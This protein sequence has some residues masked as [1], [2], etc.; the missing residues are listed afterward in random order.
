MFVGSTAA[1]VYHLFWFLNSAE[2][3][4]IF[5]PPEASEERKHVLICVFMSSRYRVWKDPSKSGTFA[6]TNIWSLRKARVWD[7]WR[8]ITSEYYPRSSRSA[9]NCAPPGVGLWHCTFFAL[10]LVLWTDILIQSRIA[11]PSLQ[12]RSSSQGPQAGPG[13]GLIHRGPSLFLSSSSSLCLTG[14]SL[15]SCVGSAASLCLSRRRNTLV[16]D[17]QRAET[18]QLPLT[19]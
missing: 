12:S 8:E 7:T 17:V 13:P 19:D 1:D 11:Q 14:D 6:K 3:S 16:S 18:L 4:R 9:A 2:R 15:R 10:S 5:L